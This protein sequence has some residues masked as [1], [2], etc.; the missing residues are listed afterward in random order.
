M[1]RSPRSAVTAARRGTVLRRFG[2]SADIEDDA[3]LCRR[4][5]IPKK[6]AQ[7]VC[8]DRVLWQEQS[9][10]K[11]LITALLARENILARPDERGR[12]RPLAA[13]VGQL[14]VV[15][16]P[17]AAGPPLTGSDE[18]LLNSYLVAAELSHIQACIVFNKIDR[19]REH[20][21][22][23]IDNYAL[24]YRRIGYPALLTSV[25]TKTGLDAL[26]AKLR[27]QRSV[28]VGQSGVGK[29]SLIRWLMPA[30][31]D[32]RVGELAATG[33]HGRHT[34]TVASLYHLPQGGDIVDSPGVRAFGLWHI[35]RRDL[36]RGFVEFARY[37]NQC[38][39]HNC[40]HRGEPQC[41][42]L[43]ASRRGDIA[44][45]RLASYRRLADQLA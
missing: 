42:V 16:A 40:L 32:I 11:A 18:D 7:L 35:G 10:G 37:Q 17:S 2:A 45:A 23:V 29:S 14:I 5:H 30:Q 25:K 26:V 33:R 9:R 27:D 21:R 12:L 22:Q 19:L 24:R 4:V 6:L 1:T 15:V 34:T 41:A 20:A 3:G 38:R 43:E 36:A 28:F 31:A 8:G 44:S 13:N 39:F